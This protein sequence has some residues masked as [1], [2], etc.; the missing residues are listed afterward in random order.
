LSQSTSNDEMPQPQS[1]QSLDESHQDST[2]SKQ[3][4]H[5]PLLR[6]SKAPPRS[7]RHLRK[8]SVEQTLFDLT[9]A[10][11]ALHK[12]GKSSSGKPPVS[13]KNSVAGTAQEFAQNAVHISE[14]QGDL[15]GGSGGAP[16]SSSDANNAASSSTNHRWGLIKG[17]IRGE[18]LAVLREENRNESTD[19][20]VE[21]GESKGQD[22][23]GGDDAVTGGMSSEDGSGDPNNIND[24]EHSG[25]NNPK[26]RKHRLGMDDKL[27]EDWQEWSE[28]FRPHKG[29]LYAYIK[30]VTLY[31]LI[32]LIGVAAILF[33]LAGNVPTGTNDSEERVDD[34]EEIEEKGA[35]ASYILLFTARLIITLSLA[36][37]I[38]FL[39]IDVV[40]LQTRFFL[41]TVG[42]V[43]TLLIV[44]SKGWPHIVFWWVILNFS[45]NYGD[46]A[47]A[48]HWAFYQDFVDLFNSTNP[49]GAITYSD[50][51]RRCLVIGISVSIV[52]TIKRFLLGLYLGRKQFSHYGELLGKVLNKMLLVSEVAR[53][54]KF[55]EK[56]AKTENTPVVMPSE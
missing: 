5:R 32:P 31:L 36:L 52:V 27:K 14:Q 12:R 50:W 22:E 48:H 53:L 1:L 39:V 6:A 11:T 13:P 33:Y 40:A 8:E 26:R 3:Q 56:T 15:N 46:H 29:R 9:K 7:T 34:D 49:S 2:D 44:Q 21:Q 38:Q 51:Y 43:I 19:S 25:S 28:F 4:Q 45:M 35:S 18:E 17:M 37:A 10:M 54:A 41:R 24:S 55:I 47:F 30:N 23:K 42:P 20:L 16:G